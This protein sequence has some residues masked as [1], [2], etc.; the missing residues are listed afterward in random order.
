MAV[1]AVA[2]DHLVAFLRRHLH[3]DDD[4]FL[5]HVAVAE[6]ADEVHAVELAGLLLETTDQQHLAISMQLFI[7][8]EFRCH[9]SL[10]TSVPDCL[11]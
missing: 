3:A 7:L 10:R 6:A 1:V 4:G 8:A 11:R 9:G 5:A 2:D